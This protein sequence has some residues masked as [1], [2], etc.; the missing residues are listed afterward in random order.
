MGIKNLTLQ[1]NWHEELLNKFE[2][3]TKGFIVKWFLSMHVYQLKT[4]YQK[5]PNHTSLYNKVHK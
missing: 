2:C 4:K 3:E 1:K 5:S